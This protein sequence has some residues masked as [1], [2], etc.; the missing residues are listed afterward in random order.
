MTKCTKWGWNMNFCSPKFVLCSVEVF[1]EDCWENQFLS[2]APLGGIL[3]QKTEHPWTIAFS[4]IYHMLGLSGTLLCICAFDTWEYNF[5]YPWTILFF[6]NIL[7][8]GSFWHFVICC[9][10]VFVFV[11]LHVW[12]M[13]VS[14]LIP[15]N[16]PLFKNIPHV[17]S[18]WH[19]V[20]CSICLFV[21]LYLCICTFDTW[22]YHF[23]Y[24]WTILFSKIYHILGL[25]GTSSYA[26]F[27]Y[28]CISVFV[29][30]YLR[31]RQIGI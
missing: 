21:Y 29:F 9:I 17:G 19:F 25:S 11:Y 26:V 16:N 2:G 23:W 1:G 5:W 28:F 6:K 3:G 22:E 18:F 10:C 30:V 8:V 24:P 13:G 15:L 27:V 4:K 31:V 12:H 7:H 14:F 20:I